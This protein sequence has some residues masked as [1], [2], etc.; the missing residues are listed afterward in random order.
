MKKESQRRDFLKTLALGGIGMAIPPTAFPQPGE[1]L[2]AVEQASPAAEQAA[3]APPSVGMGPTPAGGRKYN[4]PYS[5]EYL[6]RLAFPIGGIGAGMFCVEGTGS[7]IASQHTQPPEIYHE[8][9]SSRP[10]A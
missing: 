1:A 8:P 7:H 6:S 9:A 5:G 10:S 2:P 3:T 4:A